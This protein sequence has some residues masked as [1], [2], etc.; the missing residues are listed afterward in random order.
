MRS[1]P[2]MKQGD[3]KLDLRSTGYLYRILTLM[4]ISGRGMGNG[5]MAVSL[6]INPVGATLPICISRSSMP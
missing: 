5:V 1:I 2:N 6:R 3:R 4:V